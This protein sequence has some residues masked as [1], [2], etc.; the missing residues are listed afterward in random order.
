MSAQW[1]TAELDP[2]RRLAVLAAAIPGARVATRVIS[3]PFDDVWAVMSDLEGALGRF[4]PELRRLRVTRADGERLEAL[5]RSRL[6][7]RARFDVVLRPGWCWM[8]SRFLLVGMAARPDPAGT[9]VALTGGVRVPGRAALVP[10]FVG[11][12]NRRAAD[13]LAALVNARRS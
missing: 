4:Q 3:A 6:G 1:P 2:V 7:M 8:R 11:L 10:L 12:A 5:A 13:R 9:M